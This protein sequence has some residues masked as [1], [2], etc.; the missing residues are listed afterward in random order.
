M[1]KR[2]FY[3]PSKRIE[4]FSK[5][6]QIDLIFDLINAFKI[7]TSPAET[8]FLLRDLLT[9]KEIKNLSKRLRIAKLI[10]QGKTQRE[11]SQEVHT[12]FVT[13][14]KVRF[15]LEQGGQGLK[16]VIAKLPKRYKLPKNLPPIPLEFQLPQ[17]ISTLVQY[18]LASKD[19]K[20]GEE[21]LKGISSKRLLDKTLK[22]AFSQYFR[23]TKKR[24]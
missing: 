14:T 20:L 17:L 16:N 21:F 19:K 1:G 8:A 4:K 18:Y 5:E 7:V 22:E 24:S 11:I 9:A 10:L 15:W 12:S 2:T 3:L 23:E 6:E 13:V